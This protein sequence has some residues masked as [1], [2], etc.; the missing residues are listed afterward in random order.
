MPAAS[1]PTVIALKNQ[2]AAPAHLAVPCA[3][4]TIFDTTPPQVGTATSP[5]TASASAIP[6]TFSGMTDAVSGLKTATLWVRCNDGGWARTGHTAS[7]GAGKITFNPNGVEGMYYFAFRLEDKAGNFSPEPSGIGLTSTRADGTPPV[8]TLTGSPSMTIAQNTPFTDP[9]ATATD[10]VDGNLTPYIVVTGQVDTARPATYTLRYNVS[11]R[12]GN[13]AP[14]VTRTVTVQP[15]VA[16]MLS[17]PTNLNGPA[18]ATVAC[19]IHISETQGLTSFRITLLFSGSLLQVATVASGTATSGWGSPV[20]TAGSGSVSISASGAAL[21]P[22]SG[23]VA[24]L[25]LAVNQSAA[26]GQTSTLRFVSASLNGGATPVSIRNGEFTVT[27]AATYLYGDANGDGRVNHADAVHI[28]KRRTG[29]IRKPNEPGGEFA[30]A[31]SDVSGDDPVY[32]GTVDASLIMRFSEG[33]ISQFPIDTDG[34]GIGPEAT[35]EKAAVKAAVAQEYGDPAGATRTLNI[36]GTVTLEPGASYEIPVSVDTGSRTRG[37]FFELLYDA[38]AL[39]YVTIRNGSLTQE[40]IAPIVN[41][42]AGK[43]AVANAHVSATSGQGSLAILTFRAL[44]SVT[45]GATTHLKFE[46]ADLND[47]LLYCKECSG[48][49]EPVITALAPQMGAETGGTVVR[50]TGASLRDVSRVLFGNTASPWLRCDAAGNSIL[51]VTPSGGGAV[52]VTVESPAGT[53]TLARGFTYFLPQVHLTLAPAGSVVSGRPLEVPVWIVDLSGG[54]VS[55]VAFD[56]C[57]DPAA[58]AAKQTDG[59]FATAEESALA[60]GKTVAASLAGPGILRVTVDGA[61]GKRIGS[62]LLATCHLLA[63]SA[64]D[65]PSSLLYI[66]GTTAAS[67]DAKSLPASASMVND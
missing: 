38:R 18:G 44:P 66:S 40:W 43:I 19:P 46:T 4:V 53:S 14:E 49:G 45:S 2:Q 5:A 1:E 16:Y 61:A 15:P 65:D 63:I 52:N 58:F 62:G 51:A 3:S 27:P 64:G 12:A 8:I 23:T 34:N 22:G 37:Y 9:G 21:S 11:D 35:N 17:I 13:A 60:A 56:L 48:A 28:L 57:F 6:V 47:G 42:R 30:E 50:I 39:E 10:A 20:V 55:T 67:A 54:Q 33:L 59:T 36:P 7:T 31:A 25:N 41:P 26:P 24:V 32:A 29:L